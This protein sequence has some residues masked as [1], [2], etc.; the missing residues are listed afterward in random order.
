MW[1]FSVGPIATF[2]S[3]AVF[4]D[5]NPQGGS[6]RRLFST[7]GVTHQ[8]IA[9]VR[10]PIAPRLTSAS[11]RAFFAAGDTTAP[12]LGR[13]LW[14]TDGTAGGTGMIT[15][16]RPGE[17]DSG[18]AILTAFGNNVFLRANDG[19][20]GTELW[21][22]DGTA[23]GTQLAGDLTPTDR[24]AGSRPR[25]FISAA[26][27]TWFL[28]TDGPWTTDGTRA[29]TVP[30]PDLIAAAPGPDDVFYFAEIGNELFYVSR[31]SASPGTFVTDGTTHRQLT[32]EILS[33]NFTI[34]GERV[35]FFTPVTGSSDLNLWDASPG[36]ANVRSTISGLSN[37]GQPHPLGQ[38]VLF[39]GNDS[40]AGYELRS[41]NSGLVIDLNPG[42][43]SS[44]ALI[45]GRL[46]SN[47][48]F[49]ADDGATGN[50][51]W[52]TDGTAAGTVQ[53]ADTIPGAAGSFIRVHAQLDGLLYFSHD[54]ISGEI[55]ATDG[56]PGGTRMV[57]A[58][59]NTV[60]ELLPLNGRLLALSRGNI[61]SVIDLATS[62]STTLA[63]DVLH[64][65]LVGDDRVMFD[66]GPLGGSA[67]QIWESDGT[68]AG[69]RTIAT[70]P[71][72]GGYFLQRNG[73]LLFSAE[74][75]RFG[76][77][78]FILDIGAVAQSIPTGSCFEFSESFLSVSDPVLGTTMSVTVDHGVAGSGGLF[79]LGFPG[80]FPLTADCRLEIDLTLPTLIQ[81][82]LIALNGRTSF[83][84]PIPNVPALVGIQLS[85]QAALSPG[86]MAGGGP[87]LGYDLTQSVALRLGR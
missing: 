7:D 81:P 76:I 56:T 84:L 28:A 3:Q 50:E 53:L 62:Q 64:L 85:M 10:S 52:V 48:I 5:N 71:A 20:A 36:G 69:T 82:I 43:S 59:G 60:F 51:P 35:L 65:T 73:Q 46:G 22:S 63:M 66:T 32:S 30:R 87:V 80:Y 77:E 57:V 45:L 54:N 49:A 25:G 67:V 8:A 2:G 26:G 18:I 74:D 6:A 27:R 11:Q 21:R 38:D 70:A 75:P 41:L 23:M 15:E 34:E 17:E 44:S 33:G 55:W 1:F 83:M 12:Q 24:T 61:L 14:V 16:I 29:G 58:L 68:S 31:N 47:L 37:V 79:V 40:A 78:P 42:P 39:G 9:L 4:F 13:E 19:V 86:A 72:R